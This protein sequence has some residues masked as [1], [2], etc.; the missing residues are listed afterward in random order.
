M[1]TDASRT[2]QEIR[3]E[4]ALPN[5]SYFNEVDSHFAGLGR[6]RALLRGDVGCIRLTAL[7]GGENHKR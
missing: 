3:A 2:P 4:K 6:A 7:T 1:A 5:L